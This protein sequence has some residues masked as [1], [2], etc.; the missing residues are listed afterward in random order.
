MEI[1]SPF[2]KAKQFF[3]EELSN[4]TIMLKRMHDYHIQVQ[5]Q[6]FVGSSLALKGIVLVVYF[7]EE[8]PLFKENI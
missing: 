7:G 2:S 6:L 8:M 3:L 4:G 5:G 1:I